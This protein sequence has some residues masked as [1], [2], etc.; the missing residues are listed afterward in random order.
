MRKSASHA[1][2]T[3][4][5]GDL[6]SELCGWPDHASVTFRCPLQNQ[7]MRFSRIEGRSKVSIEI[8]LDPASENAPAVAA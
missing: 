1:G 5:V 6:I 7:A 2:T 3:I 4:T 8:E